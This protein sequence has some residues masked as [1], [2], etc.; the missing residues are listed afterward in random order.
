MSDP[1]SGL[2]RRHISEAAFWRSPRNYSIRRAE[3]CTINRDYARDRI[4]AL[5]LGEAVKYRLLTTLREAEDRTEII[6]AAYLGRAVEYA[7]HVL[8]GCG[9]TSTVASAEAVNDFIRT[10]GRD[11]GHRATAIATFRCRAL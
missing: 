9:R 4:Y 8:K 2:Q 5:S 6:C 1:L 11:A 3:Q 10:I 7:L